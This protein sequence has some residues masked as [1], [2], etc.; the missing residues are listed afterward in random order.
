MK[1]QLFRKALIIFVVV[2]GFRPTHAA[3]DVTTIFINGNIYTVA[4]KPAHAEALAVTNHR[5]AFVGSTAEAKQRFPEARVVDLNGKTVVPLCT[6]LILGVMFF[7][8][9]PPSGV[10][11]SF[12][13]VA[14]QPISAVSSFIDSI[15]SA[16]CPSEAAQ[17]QTETAREIAEMFQVVRILDIL[18]DYEFIAVPSVGCLDRPWSNPCRPAEL[19]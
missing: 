19:A 15:W 12:L 10:Q 14:A 18:L 11:K 9:V 2:L 5:I 16:C 3:E 17:S 7:H 6:R 1:A 8:S 13:F 4:E